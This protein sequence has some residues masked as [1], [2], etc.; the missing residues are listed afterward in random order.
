[1]YMSL[2]L[3]LALSP[4]FIL[5]MDILQLYSFYTYK[6]AIDGQVCFLDSRFLG[7][8]HTQLH[9]TVHWPLLHLVVWC[10]AISLAH[11][12]GKLFY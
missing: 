7:V 3:G 6:V 1:M 5:L 11:S 9:E 8:N 2:G 10:M 4:K 12:L